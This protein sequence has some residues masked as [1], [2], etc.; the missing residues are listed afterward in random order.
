MGLSQEMLSRL[1]PSFGV[2]PQVSVFQDTSVINAELPELALNSSADRKF[3][4]AEEDILRLLS[5]GH[6]QETVS[7]TLGITPSQISQYLSKDDFRSEL[8]VRKSK[9]LEKYKKLDDGYDRLEQKVMD[10]LE[11]SIMFV[12]KPGEL[13]AIL[14]RLNAAKR[15]MSDPSTNNAVPI[16][17]I[18]Q[19]VLPTA[20]IHQFTKTAEGHVVAVDS[21]SLVTIPSSVLSSLANSSLPLIIE[22]QT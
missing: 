8:S 11:Q 19:V 4:K 20:I 16:Q 21:K 22:N 2:A 14:T 13:T 9:K 7:T 3:T 10:K 5:D 15:R 6:S 18:V 1:G 17:Q 12:S